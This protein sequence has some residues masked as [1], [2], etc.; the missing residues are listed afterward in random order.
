MTNLVALAVSNFIR[1]TSASFTAASFKL[2]TFACLGTF[3]EPPSIDF[4]SR[5]DALEELLLEVGLGAHTLGPGSVPNLTRV[6]APATDIA[7]IVPG[8][9]INDVWFFNDQGPTLETPHTQAL[10]FYFANLNTK[11]LVIDEDH[12]WKIYHPSLRVQAISE[13]GAIQNASEM[14]VLANFAIVTRSP[15]SMS[16]LGVH[17]TVKEA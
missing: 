9:P 3:T 7:K 6:K 1:S 17:D 11:E 2:R 4:L 15:L 13:I 12:T 16:A 5:Q 10:G 14:P 8:C